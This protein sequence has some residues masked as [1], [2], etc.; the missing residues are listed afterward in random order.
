MAADRAAASGADVGEGLRK[1]NVA[2]SQDAPAQQ[3]QPEDMKKQAQE[4][5]RWKLDTCLR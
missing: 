4:V 5:C 1:R 3:P 2:S